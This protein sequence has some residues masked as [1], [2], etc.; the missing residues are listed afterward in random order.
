MSTILSQPLLCRN[1]VLKRRPEPVKHINETVVIRHIAHPETSPIVVAVQAVSLLI[2]S[3]I[4][5]AVG[6]LASP[7]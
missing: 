2:P 6:F 5:G 7:R 4:R 1:V 3:L